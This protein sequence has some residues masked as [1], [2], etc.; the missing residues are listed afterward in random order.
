M[1]HAREYVEHTQWNI[2]VIRK[3]NAVKK[4]KGACL[5]HEV[6]GTCGGKL[7]NC[8]RNEL[9]TSSVSWVLNE[10]DK[11]ADVQKEIR[12]LNHFAKHGTSLWT[13]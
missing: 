8:S 2:A 13:G 4:K 11:K 1:E 6:L 10:D 12:L 7:T 9:K 3:T 5:T